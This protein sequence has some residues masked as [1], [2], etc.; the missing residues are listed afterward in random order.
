MYMNHNVA[1]IDAY[2]TNPEVIQSL[3]RKKSGLK[4]LISF[5]FATEHENP[6]DL[7]PEMQSRLYL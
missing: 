2:H 7:S 1:V 3:K 6:Y 4:E 5:L